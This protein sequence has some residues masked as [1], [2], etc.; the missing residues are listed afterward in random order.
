MFPLLAQIGFK[1]LSL[2]ERPS[3]AFAFSASPS[4][5][6]PNLFLVPICEVELQSATT[7]TYLLL[8]VLETFRSVARVGARERVGA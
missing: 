1:F 3:G 7:A 5:P 6:P 2:V 8:L 4:P